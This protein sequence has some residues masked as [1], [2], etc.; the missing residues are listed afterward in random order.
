MGHFLCSGVLGYSGGATPKRNEA[1]NLSMTA[2][3][4]IRF[5]LFPF[6]FEIEAFEN[7]PV[8]LRLN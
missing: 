5:L 6:A 4:C 1:K 7:I 2:L 8:V 3:L